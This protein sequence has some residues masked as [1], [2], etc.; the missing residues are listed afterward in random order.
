[1]TDFNRRQF[2]GTGI[3]AGAAIITPDMALA[4]T[5]FIHL[6]A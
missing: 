6:T 5:D 3:L 4:N 1:M 2:L